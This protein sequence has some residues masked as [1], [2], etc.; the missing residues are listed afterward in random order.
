M[1]AMH[2]STPAWVSMSTVLIGKGRAEAVAQSTSCNTSHGTHII[3]IF[4][5]HADCHSSH[6]KL[7]QVNAGCRTMIM[8][9]ISCNR[10]FNGYHMILATG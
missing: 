4:N 6:C 8:I 7:G 5:M 2:A 1:I 10:Q 9:T 3:M